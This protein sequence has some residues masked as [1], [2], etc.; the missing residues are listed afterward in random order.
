MNYI[1][2]LKHNNEILVQALEAYQYQVVEEV[3]R[4]LRSPKFHTDTTVQ[5]QDVLNRMATG[6]TAVIH[7][8]DKLED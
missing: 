6:V 1:K 8:L 3:E 2:K 7:V 5:V 4:Y